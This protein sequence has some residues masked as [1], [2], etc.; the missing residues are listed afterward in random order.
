MSPIELLTNVARERTLTPL[1]RL[2]VSYVLLSGERIISQGAFGEALGV[3]QSTCQRAIKALVRMNVL[4]KAKPSRNEQ[5][6][7]SV[8]LDINS[9]CLRTQRKKAV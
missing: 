7:Y 1:Q 6:F 2:I 3:G 9:W 5:L 4:I 8:N